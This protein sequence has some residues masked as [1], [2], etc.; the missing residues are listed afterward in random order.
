[1]KKKFFLNHPWSNSKNFQFQLIRTAFLNAKGES[2]HANHII[3]KAAELHNHEHAKIVRINRRIQDMTNLDLE[4]AFDLKL[5]I[6]ASCNWDAPKYHHNILKRTKMIRRRQMITTK[7]LTIRNTKNQQMRLQKASAN[8]TGLAKRSAQTT[9]QQP[10]MESSRASVGVDICNSFW[11][12]P[13]HLL[14]QL[15]RLHLAQP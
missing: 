1:M 13:Y 10:R 3:S 9:M 2:E 11:I 15:L 12:W 6:L 5:F 8:Y 4:T 14:S 7:P